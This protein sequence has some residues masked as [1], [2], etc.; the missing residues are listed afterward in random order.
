MT[1]KAITG[2]E[3]ITGIQVRIETI[4]IFC[5]TNR[6]SNL[7]HCYHQRGSHGSDQ[8]DRNAVHDGHRAAGAVPVVSAVWPWWIRP[9]EPPAVVWIVLPR[10]EKHLVDFPHLLCWSFND[11]NVSQLERENRQ[12]MC[13][14]KKTIISADT[15]LSLARHPWLD[16]FQA[17]AVGT[18]PEFR[19]QL[20]LG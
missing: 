14:V 11:A 10:V 8:E 3:G 6:S 20:R 2:V 5:W 4:V 1:C 7:N 18:L 9:V 12:S 15:V 16:A 13:K 19:W 17:H